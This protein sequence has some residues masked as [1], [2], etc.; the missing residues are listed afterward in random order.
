MVMVKNFSD[1]TSEGV[2]RGR[3]KKVKRLINQYPNKKASLALAF[4]LFKN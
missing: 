3:M 4:L 1:S 2:L